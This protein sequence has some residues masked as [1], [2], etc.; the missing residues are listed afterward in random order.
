MLIRR[1]AAKHLL[2]EAAQLFA[3]SFA[4]YPFY[5]M[6]KD[7]FKTREKYIGTLA[8]MQ[9]VFLKS[10]RKS[11]N[12]I[13]EPAAWFLVALCVHRN[14]QGKHIGGK[15]FLDSI[16]PYAADKRLGC[17]EFCEETFIAGG[18]KLPNWSYKRTIG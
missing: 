16:L 7:G 15:L 10:M 2:A 4:D 12:T 18:E 11:Y 5:R 17:E 8:K 9:L 6:L 14:M 3:E 1:L 13:K